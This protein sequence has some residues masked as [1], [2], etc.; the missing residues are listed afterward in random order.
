LHKKGIS[1]VFFTILVHKLA[2]KTDILDLDTF[3]DGANTVAESATG[4]RSFV[5]PENISLRLFTP[6]KF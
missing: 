1:S 2:R 5:H 3:N 4:T 6:H